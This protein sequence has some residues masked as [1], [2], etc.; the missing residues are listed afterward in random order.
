MRWEVTLIYLSIVGSLMVSYTRARA[1]ALG[2][3]CKVGLLARPERIILLSIGLLVGWV[4]FALAI[5]AIF[6]NVTAIQRV[7]H[8]WRQDRARKPQR[9]VPPEPR[10]GRFLS[11]GE[12]PS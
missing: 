4:P 12:R 9:V 7:Y 3:D 6:T 11:R 2:F 5:M 1:E 10:R 8:V